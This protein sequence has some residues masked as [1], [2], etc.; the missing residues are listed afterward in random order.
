M[1]AI[2]L[3]SDVHATPE[4]VAEALAIFGRA[5]VKQVFCAGDIAGYRD[6][7]QQTVMLL[8]GS[9]CRSILGNHDLLYL[10]HYGDD[11]HDKA[12]AYFRE[13]PAALDVEI[14]GRKVYMV[15]AH[16]PDACHGGIKLL[17]RQGRVQPECI[18]YWAGQLGS[19]NHDVLVVGHTHQVFA[20]QI[21]N[22]LVV[23]PGSSAFNHSC[24]ILHLPEKHVEVFA[25]SGQ[26]IVKSWNWGDHITGKAG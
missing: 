12:A 3:L 10:D 23:N 15:H 20:E 13:L 9:G 1:T 19:F 14:A 6:R 17:D 7:V 25:L 24:A 8:A 11:P 21:G 22:T 26:D 16:P 5:G 4:P 18:A 2:G